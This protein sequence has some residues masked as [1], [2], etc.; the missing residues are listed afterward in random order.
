M[1]NCTFTETYKSLS[2]YHG[3]VFHLPTWGSNTAPQ[4]AFP[5]QTFIVYSMESEEIYRNMKGSEFIIL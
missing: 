3:V 4:K 5:E 1:V 2:D